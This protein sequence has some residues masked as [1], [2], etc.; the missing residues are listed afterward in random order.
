MQQAA[1]LALAALYGLGTG[2]GCTG[3]TGTSGT[4][5]TEQSPDAAVDRLEP[6]T[7]GC[8]D[9]VGES[10][11]I[12]EAEKPVPLTLWVASDDVHPML[13]EH[14]GLP[15]PFEFAW[16]DGGGRYTISIPSNWTH[17]NIHSKNCLLYTSRCV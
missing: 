10:C 8:D 17:I 14:G 12:A 1:Y 6:H 2:A 7:F 5:D 9:Y 16:I 11:L 13:I 15:V 4:D 3:S